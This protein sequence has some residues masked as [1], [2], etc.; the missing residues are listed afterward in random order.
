[1]PISLPSILPAE[2]S[3]ARHRWETL[4]LRCDDLGAFDDFEFVTGLARAQDIPCELLL[5]SKAS[6]DELAVVLPHRR[7]GPFREVILPR[8]CPTTPM[9]VATDI[10]G[11]LRADYA[12]E[13]FAH[14]A[15][16][17]HRVGIQLTATR[18]LLAVASGWKL[19]SLFTYLFDLRALQDDVTAQ[20]S[21][22]TR[23]L[24]R[25]NVDGYLLS[26]D[27][28]ATRA[29][30]ELC[31]RSYARAHRPLPVS[32][33]SMA[34]FAQNPP[35]QLTTRTFFATDTEADEPDAAIVTLHHGD[36]AFYWIAGSVPGP[37]MTVL[38]G[39]VLRALRDDGVRLF[40]FL[41]ANTPSIAEFKRRFGPALH[42]YSRISTSRSR[43][44]DLL[45]TIRG[46]SRN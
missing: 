3:E 35:G 26:E 44:F 19:T 21:A 37:A 43:W 39:H 14:V 38:M 11:E 22:S 33:A 46:Q 27:A 6:T 41:G 25:R 12:R 1:M 10:A 18:R 16:A 28:S 31:A 29:A 4:S 40:D 34:K 15:S 42:E 36:T 30:V 5:L 7:L 9:L 32:I 13:A 17:Y 2:S 24:F 8:F 45:L 23:R 20:W